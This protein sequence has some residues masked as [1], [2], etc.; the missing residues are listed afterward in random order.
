MKKLFLFLVVAIVGTTAYAQNTLVATLSHGD[1]ITMYY[2]T[3]ALRDAY[4]AAVSGDIINLSGG[5]FQAVEI[6]KAITLRGTGIDVSVPTSITGALNVNIPESDTNRFS[7]EGIRCDN[8]LSL[9]G[10]FESPQ[11][12]KCQFCPGI[13]SSSNSAVQRALFINCKITG[14]WS[15]MHGNGS[16]Q[17]INCY[18]SKL[19]NRQGS[20]S[21]TFINSVVEVDGLYL[22]G[23]YRNY[24]NNSML[25]NCVLYHRGNGTGSLPNSSTATNCV[26][27]GMPGFFNNSQINSDCNYSSYD[28]VFKNFAGEYTEGQT[29]ELT[30]VAKATCLGT[31][32]TEIGLYGGVLP[33]NTTPSYPQIT[34]MNV[35]NKTTADKKL[36]VEIEV[37]AAQ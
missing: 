10:S 24:M 32:G 23:A 6:K 31:D 11:F 18:V 7:M 19:Y 12:L 26:A 27:I 25:I 20:E 5:G 4:N 2:G 8:Y 36:S 15:E 34:K 37:S 13:S 28:A 22:S 16:F 17:F 29:F 33:F 30:D 14:R 35:A 9:D 21:Y 1:D 3:N